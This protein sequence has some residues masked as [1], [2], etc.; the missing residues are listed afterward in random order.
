MFHTSWLLSPNQFNLLYG[1]LNEHGLL[2]GAARLVSKSTASFTSKEIAQITF[3]GTFQNGDFLSGTSTITFHDHTSN[4][5]SGTFSFITKRFTGTLKKQFH[6]THLLKTGVFFWNGE[7]FNSLPEPTH[8]K[9]QLF[10]ENQLTEEREGLFLND[11]LHDDNGKEINYRVE[12]I[13]DEL[14]TT[15]ETLTS[16]FREGLHI[17]KNQIVTERQTPTHK[18]ITTYYLEVPF[19]INELFHGVRNEITFRKVNGELVWESESTLSGKCLSIDISTVFKQFNGRLTLIS[20]VCKP[21]NRD[22]Q[23]SQTMLYQLEETN[24]VFEDMKLLEGEITIYHATS[25]KTTTEPTEDD[26]K[27]NKYLILKESGIFK[28]GQ[29]ILGSKFQR[30]DNNDFFQVPSDGD[31][32]TNRYTGQYIRVNAETKLECYGTFI[33]LSEKEIKMLPTPSNYTLKRYLNQTLIREEEGTFLNWKLEGLGSRT[34]YSTPSSLHS[35]NSRLL[36]DKLTTKGIFEKG[37]A[38]KINMI[39][40]ESITNE[41][42]INIIYTFT[43]NENDLYTG[44]MLLLI[45]TTKLE[46][47]KRIIWTGTMR[48]IKEPGQFN[49]LEGEAILTNYIEGKPTEER[50][51]KGS[52]DE[53]NCLHSLPSTNLPCQEEIWQLN[54][55]SPRLLIS[56]TTGTFIFGKIK[57]GRYFKRENQ[58]E[59]YYIGKFSGKRV[60]E[61]PLGK[62]L[63]VHSDGNLFVNTGYDKGYPITKLCYQ[64]QIRSR[65]LLS[66][67]EQNLNHSIQYKKIE[68]DIHGRYQLTTFVKNQA[69][70]TTFIPSTDP[71]TI[72]FKEHELFLLELERIDSFVQ[73]PHTQEA[74]SLVLATKL[75]IQP[76]GDFEDLLKEEKA[77]KERLQEAKRLKN[78]EKD[79]QKELI[80]RKEKEKKQK[81]ESAI[82]RSKKKPETPLETMK[83]HPAYQVQMDAIPINDMDDLFEL[84]S[85]AIP[86]LRPTPILGLWCDLEIE[87]PIIYPKLLQTQ[88][89]NET[90][91]PIETSLK[92]QCNL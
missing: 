23:S 8:Y 64:L 78:A 86:D 10:E 54:G 1:T 38:T 91:D 79:K 34:E 45:K 24:G 85:I 51:Y 77:E 53:S 42:I 81:Q 33:D 15:T 70:V 27:D 58:F 13:N 16:C 32:I 52:F 29:L 30:T 20:S 69:T 41:Q 71:R 89:K 4:V 88:A 55:T 14:E 92:I 82:G 49:L 75:K 56:R 37:V 22:E 21:M 19:K 36:T 48:P 3:E 67:T 61:D 40:S 66:I 25:V 46:L 63:E 87:E 68:R 76:A 47:N 90:T 44:K 57:E 60:Y 62:M 83:A 59:Y 6:T 72:V 26:L 43:N 73:Q 39:T 84:G 17:G 35:S 5:L 12:T 65:M 2:D 50:I 74:C 31:H 7:S 11:L 9:E 18:I 28:N 80:L